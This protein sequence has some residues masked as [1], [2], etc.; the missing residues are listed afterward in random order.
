MYQL[1][2]YNKYLHIILNSTKLGK[3]TIFLTQQVKLIEK[4]NVKLY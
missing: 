2:K 1:Y 3:L 4:N